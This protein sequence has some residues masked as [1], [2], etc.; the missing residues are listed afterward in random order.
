[1]RSAHRQGNEGTGMNEAD[2]HRAADAGV[3]IVL[4]P[5]ASA[6]PLGFFAFACGCFLLSGLQLHWVPADEGKQ[7]AL[8]E[9]AFVAPLQLGASLLGY[10]ARDVGAG[11]TLGLFGGC[12]TATALTL[13]SLP[14][15]ATSRALGLFLCA[16][17]VPLLALA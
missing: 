1:M 4:R 16:F 14:P 5:L 17:A 7:V 11:T 13:L 2:D 12:W 6:L 3:R 10:A 8:I 9:L 15:A